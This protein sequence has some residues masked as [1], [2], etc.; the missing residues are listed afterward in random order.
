[1][2]NAQKMNSKIMSTDSVA[3]YSTKSLFSLL[4]IQHLRQKN[5]RCIFFFFF[6]IFSSIKKINY[7]V[8]VVLILCIENV[9]WQLTKINKS[10]NQKQMDSTRKRCEFI[11]LNKQLANTFNEIYL[12]EKCYKKDKRNTFECVRYLFFDK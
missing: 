9:H 4:N 12:R 3:F 2:R 1:M 5:M 11:W 10:K 7:V 6:F 8:D